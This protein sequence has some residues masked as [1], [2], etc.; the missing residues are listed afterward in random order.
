MLRLNRW[1][2][3]VAVRASRD[4]LLAL[5]EIEGLHEALFGFRPAKQGAAYER[6]TAVVLAVFGWTDVQHD[7]REGIEGKRAKHQLD[8][9]ARHPTG[10]IK[11]LIV[12]CKDWDKKVGKGTLDALVGVLGQLNV[13]DGAVVTTKDFTKGARAV[14]ADNDIALVLIRPFDTEDPTP[15]VKR[16]ELT[17]NAF[18]SVYSDFNV[19]ISQDAPPNPRIRMNSETRLLRADSSP[20]ESFAEIMQAHHGSPLQEGTYP[21]RVT[22]EDGRLLP[23]EDGDGP[24]RSLAARRRLSLKLKAS[25]SWS[26]SNWTRTEA[27]I[28]AGSSSIG[29]YSRGTSTPTGTS[30]HAARSCQS[31]R[32]SPDRA[33][34]PAVPER[35]RR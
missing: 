10:L 25:P 22:F 9:T 32:A 26:C 28:T 17:I 24:R 23:V 29:S 2:G 35:L 20:A 4:I 5:S 27:S 15:Y 12:E 18:G 30:P 14:A 8:V 33:R 11:R 31:D 34:P 16:I 7:T 13:K 1:L 6:L 21:Q 19:E 3:R